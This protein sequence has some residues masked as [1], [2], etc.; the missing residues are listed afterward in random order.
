MAYRFPS[1]VRSS[2]DRVVQVCL[3]HLDGDA[4]ATPALR[5]RIARTLATMMLV[6]ERPATEPEAWHRLA[7]RFIGA[8]HDALD[9][10]L[11]LPLGKSGQPIAFELASL[12][13]DHP[14]RLPMALRRVRFFV[15]CLSSMLR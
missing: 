12:P 8:T 13:D 14:K 3:G 10:A 7:L 15:E 11:G 9:L 4:L 1:Q 6:N 2:C 5:G